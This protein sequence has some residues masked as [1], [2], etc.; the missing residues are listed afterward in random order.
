MAWPIIA[1]MAA[2]EG[3]NQAG[4][5]IGNAVGNKMQ[6][7]QNKKLLQQQYEYNKKW[8]KFQNQMALDMWHATNYSAQVK[9]LDKA[10]LNRGLMY[11]G[12]GPGGALAQQPSGGASGASA[13]NNGATS[14][15]GLQVG[16]NAAM[17]KKQLK[18]IKLWHGQ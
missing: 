11:E 12:S 2:G 8:G 6:R 10:G 7:S 13:S 16:I 9:E 5:M 17:A 18:Q 15:M 1:Q 14:G 4:Q 3:I